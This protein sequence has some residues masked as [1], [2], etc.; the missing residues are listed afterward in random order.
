[1]AEEL[2]S[3][4]ALMNIAKNLFLNILQSCCF[5][6]GPEPLTLIP[7]GTGSVKSSPMGEE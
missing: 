3:T 6:N 2:E 5:W 4:M 7:E 1:M